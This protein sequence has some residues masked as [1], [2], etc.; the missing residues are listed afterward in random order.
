MIIER[1]D[2]CGDIGEYKAFKRLTVQRTSFDD[3]YHLCVACYQ[4]FKAFISPEEE[5]E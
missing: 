2:K 5:A 1:C 4:A 3:E